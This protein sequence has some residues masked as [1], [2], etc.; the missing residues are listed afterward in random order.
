[1]SFQVFD[2]APCHIFQNFYIIGFQSM[3]LM[4][5]ILLLIGEIEM[6]VKNGSTIWKSMKVFYIL[7]CV[8]FSYSNKYNSK[9]VPFHRSAK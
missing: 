1:M 3:Y 4:Y 7:L 8:F 6:L 9:L 2:E 5:T